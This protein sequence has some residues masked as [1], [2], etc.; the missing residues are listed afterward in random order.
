MVSTGQFFPPL[1]LETLCG[2]V[3][4]RWNEFITSP[5]LAMARAMRTTDKF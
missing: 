4:K 1:Q 3:K 2:E 5:S